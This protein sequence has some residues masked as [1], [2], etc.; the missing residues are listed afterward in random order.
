MTQDERMF[1]TRPMQRGEQTQTST[2][3]PTVKAPLNW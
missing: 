3:I 1:E 2:N